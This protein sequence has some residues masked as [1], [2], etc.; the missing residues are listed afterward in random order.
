MEI[1]FLCLCTGHRRST[2]Q[3]VRDGRSR[4]GARPSVA[5]LLR[6]GRNDVSDVLF[7]K[8]SVY[9]WIVCQKNEIAVQGQSRSHIKI[10]SV[11]RDLEIQ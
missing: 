11:L 4:A 5:I 10:K 8:I 6:R 7:G 9:L 2:I 3:P 1:A